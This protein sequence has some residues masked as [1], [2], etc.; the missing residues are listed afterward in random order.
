MSHFKVI[1]IALIPLSLLTGC[2]NPIEKVIHFTSGYMQETILDNYNQGQNA[3]NQRNTHL[4]VISKGVSDLKSMN[5]PDLAEVYKF[6]DEKLKD[7]ELSM[8]DYNEIN[9]MIHKHKVAINKANSNHQDDVA[10]FKKNLA[11]F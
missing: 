7:N 6:I 11:D 2:D 3:D 4:K 8:Y 5:D 9:S 10:N 1:L